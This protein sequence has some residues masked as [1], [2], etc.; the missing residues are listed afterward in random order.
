[1]NVFKLRRQLIDDYST[2]IHS[3]INIQDARIR[4]HVNRELQAGTLWPDPLIQLN[5]TF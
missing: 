2:Y 5:P 1:M 3:F 4:D